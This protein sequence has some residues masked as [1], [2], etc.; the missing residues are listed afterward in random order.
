[1]K[2][3]PGVQRRIDDPLKIATLLEHRSIFATHADRAT[4]TPQHVDQSDF[5]DLQVI[6]P[7]LSRFA[8]PRAD[9]QPAVAIIKAVEDQVILFPILRLIDVKALKAD[10]ALAIRGENLDFGISG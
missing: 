1:M 9:V 3:V 10:R 8:G 6:P 4:G 5:F 2:R 7:E